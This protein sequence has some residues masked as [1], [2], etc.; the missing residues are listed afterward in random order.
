MIL[1]ILL[2]PR[3]RPA[4]LL[5]DPTNFPAIPY[6]SQL[7]PCQ[8]CLHDSAIS[9]QPRKSRCIQRCPITVHG[10]SDG[11]LRCIDQLC[12]SQKDLQSALTESSLAA[13][14]DWLTNQL[15]CSSLCKLVV[16]LGSV[17]CQVRCGAIDI[18]LGVRLIRRPDVDC[19]DLVSKWS[20]AHISRTSVEGAT[21]DERLVNQRKTV[22]L[23]ITDHASDPTMCATFVHNR[24]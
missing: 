11:N 5:L 13:W 16:L 18:Q 6:S 4:V 22:L 20:K 19:D 21:L 9:R 7:H 8:C 24:Y 23:R 14:K 1:L 10:C 17:A 15:H 3:Q 2:Q 12:N